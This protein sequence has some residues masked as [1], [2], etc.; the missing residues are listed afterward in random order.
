MVEVTHAIICKLC[1]GAVD[2]NDTL[3]HL[4]KVHGYNPNFISKNNVNAYYTVVPLLSDWP[5]I[6]TPKKKR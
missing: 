1:R 2:S 3:D 6:V 5:Q 4:G